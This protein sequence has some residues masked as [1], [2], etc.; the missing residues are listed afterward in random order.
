MPEISQSAWMGETKDPLR[1]TTVTE[2]PLGY[3]DV[4]MT[5]VGFDLGACCQNCGKLGRHT[6][7]TRK[8]VV[9]CGD[10]GALKMDRGNSFSQ[11]VEMSRHRTDI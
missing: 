5:M 7:T 2:N 6:C 1:Y 4:P 11:R 3:R 8:P 10:Y 9:I